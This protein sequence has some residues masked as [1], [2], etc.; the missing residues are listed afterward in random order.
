MTMMSNTVPDL[1]HLDDQYSKAEAP[2]AMGDNV[3]DGK[4]QVRVESVVLDVTRATNE[5]ILKWQ[6]EVLNGEHAGRYIFRNNL[7]ASEDNLR[8]LKADLSK[9]GLELQRLS[10]LPH[11]LEELLD[12][13]LEI[14]QQTKKNGDKEYRNVYFQKRIAQ[15]P[16]AGGAFGKGTDHVRPDDPDT[17]F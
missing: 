16:R 14:K 7:F 5:P 15:T 4:Y 17:P 9:C 1:S 8:F 11:R 3:P 12:I 10:D 13:E 2:A 6:L